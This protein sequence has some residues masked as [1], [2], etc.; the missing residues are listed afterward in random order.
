MEA[1][2]DALLFATD[3]ERATD[4]QLF[5]GERA[6]GDGAEAI[7]AGVLAP[8]LQSPMA[9]C[10]GTAA[11][12]EALK[13]RF[14]PKRGRQVLI[15]IHGYFT[16]FKSA[17]TDAA[18]LQKELA[19][20]GPLVVF[21]WPARVTTRAAYGT[22]EKNAGWAMQHFGLL[23]ADIQRAYPGI[24]VSFAVHSLGSR[25]LT[26]G[27][28]TVTRSG[29]KTCFARA[30]VF[31]PDE[32]VNELRSALQEVGLC[33]GRPPKAPAHAA[34]VTI[35]V[36]N[37]DRALRAS[38][39]YHGG[40]QRA[41]QAGSAMLLCRGVDTIDV[42]YFGGSDKYGH[43]YHLDDPIT[44]DARA[45]LAGA[46]PEGPVRKLKSVSRAGGLYYELGR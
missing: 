20:P 39:R 8:D 43:T 14:D 34:P 21:S 7:T 26:F 17:A 6:E 15:Y 25:F 12:V 42:S 1:A 11:L 29:C 3:R 44:L 30:V 10:T 4:A 27:V 37:S 28:K 36:S 18:E 9:T 33:N 32:D 38:Q 5:T 45:A 22:D 23:L 2:P 46:S 19:F 31:A 16:S 35:Y 13:P 40:R 41:G 24:P